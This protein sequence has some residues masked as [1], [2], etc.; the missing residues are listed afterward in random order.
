MRLFA[1]VFVIASLAAI[2]PSQIFALE[3]V[4]DTAGANVVKF[5]SDAPLDDFEGVTNRIDG[6]VW[7]PGP[8]S[9]PQTKQQLD[10]S[11]CYFEVDLASLDTG[12]GL[13]NRH[14][15][16]KYLHTDKHPF[17]HFTGSLTS[18]NPITDTSFTAQSRGDLFIHGETRQVEP[19]LTVYILEGQYRVKSAF[20][21]KLPD[22][23]IEVPS[24]MFMKISEDIDLELDFYMQ[25]TTE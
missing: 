8:D 16:E 1:T 20:T 14:M 21:V 2:L 4:V 6:Y 22:Y 15:R 24:L 10:S 13:R 18:I 5:I 17:A 11:E 12:I 19:I 9:L 7:W 23:K 3:C 25:P